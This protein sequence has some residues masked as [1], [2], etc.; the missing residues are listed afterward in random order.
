MG[1]P[2]GTSSLGNHVPFHPQDIEPH[3]S[4]NPSISNKLISEYGSK[5]WIVVACDFTAHKQPENFHG[6][7][8]LPVTLGVEYL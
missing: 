6:L 5:F 2:L 4:Y 8:M 3:G 1:V 7:N